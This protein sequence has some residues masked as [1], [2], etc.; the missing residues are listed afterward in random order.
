[1][2]VINHKQSL[3]NVLNAR[4][5]QVANSGF[6]QGEER[7]RELQKIDDELNPLLNG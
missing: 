6:W 3:I 5:K 1:M 7:E 4:R 2:V